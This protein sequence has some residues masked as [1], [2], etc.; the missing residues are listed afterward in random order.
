MWTFVPFVSPKGH[1]VVK[2]SASFSR[3]VLLFA[4][5]IPC[6]SL[7]IYLLCVVYLTEQTVV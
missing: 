7:S 6:L 1:P 5:H 2:L 4:W 3:S